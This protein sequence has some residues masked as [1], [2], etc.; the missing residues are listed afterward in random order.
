[1]Q[2]YSNDQL[3]K[4]CNSWYPGQID[5]INLELHNHVHDRISLSWHLT[6]K[7][8]MKVK[9]SVQSANNK[10]SLRKLKDLIE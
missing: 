5:V 6:T 8:R 4:Y 9:N 10:E 2:D 3:I 7:E 1:M